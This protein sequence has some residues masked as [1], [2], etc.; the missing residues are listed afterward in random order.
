MR[1]ATI[2]AAI[3]G[4]GALA[5]GCA[6]PNIKPTHVDFGTASGTDTITMGPTLRMVM[7]RPRPIDAGPPIPTQCSEPSPDAVIAFTR[8]L[9]GQANY[10]E[11]GGPTV[12]GNFTAS[13]N[14]TATQ[15]PGRT[16]GV[17]ALRDGLFA[18]CQAYANGVLGHDAYALILSQYGN[19]LVAVAGQQTGGSPAVYSAQESMTVGLL[20]ACISEN[21]PTRIRPVVH[22]KIALNPLLRPEV[23]RQLIAKIAA[24]AAP[25]IK[26]AKAQTP[27]ANAKGTQQVTK[28]AITKTVTKTSGPAPAPAAPGGAAAGGAQ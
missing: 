6:D 27:A 24:A 26:V 9:Q 4:L 20:V 13:A 7:E 18:A 3:C 5:A 10:S 25:K 17:L 15:L 12:G 19:L 23:C 14:E 2:V 11:T 28:T 21:D 8:S 22:G 1:F 16:Q